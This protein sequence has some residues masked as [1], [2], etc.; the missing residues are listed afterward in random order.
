M[1][2]I[3]DNRFSLPGVDKGKFHFRGYRSPKYYTHNS[4]VID[5]AVLHNGFLSLRLFLLPTVE[6]L[7]H[8]CPG[9]FAANVYRGDH[10]LPLDREGEAGQLEERAVFRIW[11]SVHLEAYVGAFHLPQ[12]LPCELPLL[13]FR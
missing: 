6:P 3:R 10:L 12:I 1:H 7:V 13:R 8:F 9:C 2:C 5:T 11:H 4:P